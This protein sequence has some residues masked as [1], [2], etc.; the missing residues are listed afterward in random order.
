M[1]TQ[2]VLLAHETAKRPRPTP[3]GVDQLDPSKVTAFPWLSTA[4]QNSAV[5]QDTDHR[6]PAGSTTAGADQTEPLYES[7][8]P[9][10]PTAAQK[11][12]V[13]QETDVGRPEV[14][15]GVALPHLSEV[16]GR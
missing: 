6:P 16:G 3:T 4:A 15:T 13:G 14:S 5:G 10:D 11:V 7:A 12:G 8:S 2:N 1:V 9:L